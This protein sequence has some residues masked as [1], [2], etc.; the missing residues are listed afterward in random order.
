MVRWQIII[1]WNETL[2]LFR[3]SGVSAWYWNAPFFKK[4][5]KKPNSCYN[6][7]FVAFLYI[8]VTVWGRVWKIPNSEVNNLC[9]CLLGS[10]LSRSRSVE[11]IKADKETVIGWVCSVLAKRVS[12]KNHFLFW[13]WCWFLSCVDTLV[14]PV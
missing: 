11:E 2:L 9:C 4:K 13:Q 3:G 14:L 6:F 8:V 12:S 1:F 7:C 5:N 10:T